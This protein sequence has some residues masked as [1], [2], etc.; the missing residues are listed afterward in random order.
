MA[1]D[2]HSEPPSSKGRR[3]AAPP[4]AEVA[5]PCPAWILRAF[6][7]EPRPGDPGVDR[8]GESI[9]APRP[10]PADVLPLVE[11]LTA[12]RTALVA[13]LDLPPAPF[14]LQPCVAI[15][16]AGVWLESIRRDVDLGPSGPRARLGTLQEDLRFLALLLRG[17]PTPTELAAARGGG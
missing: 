6:R 14:K 15:T 1:A 16:D 3:S 5:E 10:W 8:D 12:G 2:P 7:D 17:D 4:A 11:R 13:W 9:V